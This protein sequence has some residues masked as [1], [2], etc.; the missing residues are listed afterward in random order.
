MKKYSF[1]I[2]LLLSVNA[3]AQS[4]NDEALLYSRNGMF[5]TARTV[6]AGGAFGSVGADLGSLA[7]N[8]A[9]IGLFRSM[10]FSLTPSLSIDK[11]EAQFNGSFKNQTTTRVNFS[12]A[13][14]V[15]TKLL[16]QNKN[17]RY[18]FNSNKLKSISF[19]INYQRRVSFS[20]AQ[21]FYGNN[22]SNS[23]IDYYAAYANS[24]NLPLTFDNFPAELVLASQAELMGF[25]SVSQSYQSRV[26]A[27]LQQSGSVATKGG[28]D[29][30]D[31]TF[32]GNVNDKLYFGA[33]LG[34]PIVTYIST[35]SFSEVNTSDSLSNF[36]DYT[37]D[38]S[39]RT[40]GLG[41]TG[42]FGLI[43]RPVA[44]AR[45]GL[46]YHLPSFYSLSETYSVNLLANYDTVYYVIPADYYPFKY[47]FRTPMRG[48]ASASFYIKEHGFFSVDYEFLNYGSAHYNFGNDYKSTTEQVNTYQKDH[49]T[50]GHV[51]RAGF[52]GAYKTLRVRTGY[53][54]TSTPYKKADI[55]KN[56]TEAKHNATAGLGYRGRRF[57]ADFAYV[58]G[59][60][61][62]VNL[63]YADFI[64]KNTL[65]SHAL[66]LTVGWKISKDNA[67]AKRQ[68]A[69]ERA[70]DM[71]Y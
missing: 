22:T 45:I 54:F 51:V 48:V 34:I 30:I 39:L 28:V 43:Y 29:Q 66:Y 57:Y 1:Y 3:V 26:R 40:T 19:A 2:L 71:S 18:S 10:D 15:F 4:Y 16:N 44:W 46:A 42:K 5:G 21:S 35:S 69:P 33:T 58:F 6:G 23:A 36:W 12:Q 31:L 67:P 11:N 20:G 37:F 60:T 53:S 59:F 41:I 38:A 61:K 27:P 47:K 55:T 68:R 50:F 32:G 7:I 17:S 56:Y 49:Y 25:D 14:I 8:P 52:E 13:G 65:V 9:G 64:V 62:A 70:P 63:P 24:N